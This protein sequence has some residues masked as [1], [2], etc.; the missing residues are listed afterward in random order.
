MP[1]ANEAAKVQNPKKSELQISGIICIPHYSLPILK[2]LDSFAYLSC[3][4]A[5]VVIRNSNGH[6]STSV[7]MLSEHYTPKRKQKQY[8]L[9]KSVVVQDTVFLKIEHSR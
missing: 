5:W 4:H 2:C 8:V 6:R 3:L 1:T 9:I 7:E